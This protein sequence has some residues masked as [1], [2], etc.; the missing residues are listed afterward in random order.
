[1]P[2]SRLAEVEVQLVMQCCEQ[3][4]FL[5]VARCSRFTLRAADHAFAWRY[6]RVRLRCGPQCPPRSALDRL[7]RSLLH[8]TSC[9]SVEWQYE[10]GVEFPMDAEFL[11]L[12]SL[13]QL[14]GLA[15]EPLLT[16]DRYC[17]QILHNRLND[18]FK[19]MAS[20]PAGSTATV[21][22]DETGSAA[23]LSPPLLTSLSL[24]QSWIGP[25]MTRAL[26][27][28][29]QHRGSDLQLLDLSENILNDDAM[30]VLCHC[31][32]R[33]EHWSDSG[34]DAGGLAAC[35]RPCASSSWEATVFS[36]RD[37]RRS[38][39]NFGA[40]AISLCWISAA[41]TS[42]VPWLSSSLSC[43][44][45]RRCACSIWLTA[46]SWTRIWCGCPLRLLVA[47]NFIVWI[48]AAIGYCTMVRVRWPL[49]CWSIAPSV[50]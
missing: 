12:A 43:P 16:F 14:R 39:R 25:Y 31:S 20:Q 6:G 41:V 27:P 50:S 49:R 33:P 3:R 44:S 5:A 1:M 48:C 24:R 42:S 10:L 15:I 11:S 17:M 34:S 35:T 32:H 29:L 38:L 26:F 45:A 37:S 13:P 21:T 8:R 28:L 18:F 36:W 47:C 23:L 7:R 9:V 30:R 40:G 19:R 22:G 46:A 4:T 2:F